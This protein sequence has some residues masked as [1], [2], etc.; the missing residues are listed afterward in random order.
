MSKTHHTSRRAATDVSAAVSSAEAQ[1]RRSLSASDASM[2][3][4]NALPLDCIHSCYGGKTWSAAR[5]QQLRAAA[6]GMTVTARVTTPQR[7]PKRRHLDAY[8]VY[9]LASVG[10]VVCIFARLRQL[11]KIVFGVRRPTLP[12][13]HAG[14]T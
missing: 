7:A 6:A 14:M 10:R 2:V 12:D 1:T 3:C 4:V 11:S 8:L 9:C 5:M 13:H